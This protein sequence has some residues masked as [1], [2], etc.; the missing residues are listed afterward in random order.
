[1]YIRRKVFS[2]IQDEVGEVKLFSTT[3]YEM[4]ENMEVRLFAEK[5]KERGHRIALKDFESHRGLG[6]S[7]L[8]GDV[9]GAL[10][11]ILVKK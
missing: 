1:M 7:L 5:K 11:D 6:R 2:R 4:N 8:I 9:G 3:D 10:G